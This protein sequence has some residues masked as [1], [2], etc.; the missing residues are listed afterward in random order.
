MVLKRNLYKKFIKKPIKRVYKKKTP[1]VKTIK[2]IVKKALAKEIEN[3]QVVVQDNIFPIFQLA[4]N[5]ITGTTVETLNPIIVQG[6]GENGRIGNSVKV[7]KLTLTGYLCPS[8]TII[9]TR[10]P[11]VIGQWNVRVF[12]GRLKNTIN[13]PVTTDLNILMRTGANTQPFDSSNG[14]SLCRS[15]NHELFTIYYDKIHKIGF[16]NGNNASVATGLHNNDYKL[17]KYLKIDLTKHVKKNLIFTEGSNN[18][19]NMGLYMWAGICDSLCSGY[20]NTAGLVNMI[21]DLEYIYED[22]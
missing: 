9:D 17:S 2:T 18:P 19:T 7:K 1:M 8:A 15:V 22:A 3:K 20:T 12:I 5:T 6:V 16:Q 4:S 13:Q 21:Y 11:A 10:V 14:L